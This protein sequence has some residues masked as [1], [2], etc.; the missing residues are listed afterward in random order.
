[1]STKTPAACRGLY[2]FIRYQSAAHHPLLPSP[3]PLRS[4]PSPVGASGLPR[5]GAPPSDEGRQGCFAK[6]AGH[7]SLLPRAA[8]MSPA[9]SFR[10][11]VGE[12]VKGEGK[13]MRVAGANQNPG[14][15]PGL[16]S[17]SVRLS[18]SN[19]L[20]TL[21]RFTSVDNRLSV[22]RSNP[23]STLIR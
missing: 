22:L 8:P 13:G 16:V 5:R 1:M 11:Q 21:V 15:A 18:D 4:T 9:P 23:L 6:G 14:C 7:V 12:R 10:G 17:V 2:P 3:R 19:P 20:T